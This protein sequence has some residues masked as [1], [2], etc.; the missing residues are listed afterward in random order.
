MNSH[1]FAAAHASSGDAPVTRRPDRATHAPELRAV[2][3]HDL[4]RMIHL[5]LRRCMAEAMLQAG[6]LDADDP[7]DVAAMNTAMQ[8][9][10]SLFRGHLAT[11][12][13]LVHPAIEARA[14]GV[15]RHIAGDHVEHALAIDVLAR[16]TAELR[17]ASGSTARGR[18]ARDLYRELAAFVADNLTHMAYEEREH[19]AALWAAYTDDELLELE[20]NIVASIPPQKMFATLRWMA[21][22][23]PPAE[24]AQLFAKLRAMAPAELVDGVLGVVQPELSDRD[25]RK[26][27][28]SFEA[29]G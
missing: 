11:E 14:P 25:W 21:T 6:R 7:A 28:A 19:N 4:Y 3:R 23:C 12:D 1:A 9:L 22:A 29:R 24:R 13:A 10:I 8:E 16:T 2:A 17:S 27:V 5:A 18:A 26:L 15:T 20:R